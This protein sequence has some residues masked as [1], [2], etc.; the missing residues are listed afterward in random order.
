MK[1]F[2]K[3]IV[4]VMMLALVCGHSS[5]VNAA[6]DLEIV[7]IVDRIANGSNEV[8]GDGVGFH[9][10]IDFKSLSPVTP[11][12][13]SGG[14]NHTHQYL[15]SRGIAILKSD[16]NVTNFTDSIAS[17]IMEYADKPDDDDMGL[18][19]AS[20]FWNPETDKNYLGS[21]SGTAKTR[22]FDNYDLAVQ[23]YNTNRSL[24]YQYLGRAMHYLCD[25]G[26]PHHSSNQIAVLSNHSKFEKYADTNRASYKATTSS[27]YTTCTSNTLTTV[28]KQLG[29]YSKSY[30]ESVKTEANWNSVASATMKMTQQYVAGVLYRFL[31]DVGAK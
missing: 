4:I 5:Y 2:K 29:T 25:I 28:L 8:I 1:Q 3:V 13:T 12:W 23:Y 15:V 27:K 14:V 20:H 26:E 30:S 9:Q 17:I 7:S 22:F 24:S 6:D 11:Y 10:V 31:K 18:A 21:K 16:K 19:F